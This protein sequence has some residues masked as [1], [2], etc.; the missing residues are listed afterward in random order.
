MLFRFSKRYLL[1]ALLT[2]CTSVAFAKPNVPATWQPY[3]NQ[4]FGF[5]IDHPANITPTRQF[6]QTYHLNNNWSAASSIRTRPKQYRI[7]ELPIFS[8]QQQ[9]DYYFILVRIGASANPI[10][11]KNCYR[12][13]FGKTVS[14]TINGTVWQVI[15]L[16]SV[17]MM[18][19]MLGKSYRTKHNGLC[20]ALELIET[21]GNQHLIKN[22]KKRRQTYQAIAQKIIATFQFTH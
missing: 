11:L 7:V 13:S 1:L 3:K 5:T 4:H 10:D 22:F 12:A 6:Q 19:F 17:G 8:L 18:Q 21:G 20:Y 16:Q 15:N 14:T 9:R 2:S